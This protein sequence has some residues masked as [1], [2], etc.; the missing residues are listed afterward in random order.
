MTKSLRILLG[1]GILAAT[2]LG[3][4]GEA[5]A[6]VTWGP[7]APTWSEAITDVNPT[8]PDFV[9]MQVSVFNGSDFSTV[10]SNAGP[11]TN[12]LALKCSD[13]SIQAGSIN[14]NSTTNGNL[15]FFC[16]FFTSALYGTGQ[17]TSN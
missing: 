7:R 17:I 5:G 6:T 3:L 10:N 16:P 9:T 4:S 11:F 15:A 1:T 8:S 12:E 14:G 13:G 2:A